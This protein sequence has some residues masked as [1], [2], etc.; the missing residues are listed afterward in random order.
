MNGTEEQIQQILD[1]V[2][3]IEQNR[4]LGIIND[5]EQSYNDGNITFREFCKELCKQIEEGD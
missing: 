1:D 5:L 3:K 4:I 2:K